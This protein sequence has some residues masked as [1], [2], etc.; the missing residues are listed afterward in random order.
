MTKPAAPE[1]AEAGASDQA[2]KSVGA[3]ARKGKAKA[4]AAQPKANKRR[5]RD[6]EEPGKPTAGASPA[7]K[8]GEATDMK[9][10]SK[11]AAAPKAK[12][13]KAAPGA[14]EAAGKGDKKTAAKAK[15]AGR[16]KPA[17]REDAPALDGETGDVDMDD[18]ACREE[19]QA[20]PRARGA[21]KVASYK[22]GGRGFRETADARLAVKEEIAAASEADAIEQLGSP[23]GALRCR[24]E[25]SEYKYLDGCCCLP[26]VG[27]SA[28]NF[29]QFDTLD[30]I[31]DFTILDEQKQLQPL[32]QLLHHSTPLTV[33]GKLLAFL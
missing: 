11:E 18:S 17:E 32:D 33:S 10:K 23:A 28:F 26:F 12:K 27:V 30:R 6:I 1:K 29:S 22:E 19:L 13:G 31:V 21:T 7:G 25:L 3:A 2:V 9:R 8:V 14:N 24:Q 15:R 16:A 20:A 4:A 5:R